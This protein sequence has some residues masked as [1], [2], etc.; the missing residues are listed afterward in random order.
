MCSYAT[1]PASSNP[2]T[3]TCGSTTFLPVGA[4][5]GRYTRSSRSCVKLTISSSTTRFCPL[6]RDTG[7]TCTSFRPVAD[8]MISVEAL[9][10]RATGA[11][12][13]RGNVGQIWLGRHC[14][15]R[16]GDILVD[17]LCLDVSIE[18]RPEIHVA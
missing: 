12:R 14:C 8:E 5:P 3:T 1:R 7:F 15:H 6:V 9:D 13:E 16:R 17:K 11:S 18:N 10:L 2:I 4:T